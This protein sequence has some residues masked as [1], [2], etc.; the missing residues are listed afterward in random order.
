MS[1]KR[2]FLAGLAG[3]L[4]LAWL[5]YSPGL[6]GG[7]LFDDYVNLDALGFESPLSN[8]DAF[9]RYLSS[10]QADPTGR[11]VAM[12][13]FLLDAQTWPAAPAPFLRTNLIIH[14]GNGALLALLLRRLGREL[15]DDD[16]TCV[17]AALL[18][19]GLWLLHPL[20]VSTT[21][22]VVQRQAMLATSF[23]LLG[24]LAWTHGR[25]RLRANALRAG[26]AWM[27]AG[28]LAGGL[29]AG[30]SKANGF[31]L[32]LLALAIDWVLGARDFSATAERR[33]GQCRALLLVAP[34]AL[35][36]LALATQGLDARNYAGRDFTLGTRL[37]SEARVMVDYLRLLAVP[38][39]MSDGVFNDAF[40]ASTSW[41]SPATTLPAALLVASLLGA[42]FA[43]RRRA[44]AWSMGLLFFFAGHV[45][46]ST[47]LPLE[48]RYEHRNYLPA[49]LLFWP[50]A[51][52]LYRCRAAPALRHAAALALVLLV[53]FP[54]WQ[55]A[56]LW[57]DPQRLAATWLVAHPD[58]SRAIAA[59]AIALREAGRPQDA[60]RLLAGAWARAPNDAQIALNFV[61][62]RCAAGQLQA[63]DLRLLGRALAHA[64]AD[65]L[66]LRWLDN[67]IG[68]APGFA[69][70]LSPAQVEALADIVARNPAFAS[71]R[72]RQNLENL[73]GRIA[74]ARGEPAEAALH[75][76]QSL[77]AEVRP[78]VAAAQAA[79]LIDAGYHREAMQQLDYYESVSDRQARPPLGM[80]RVHDWLLRRQGY[81][82]DVFARLR[83]SAQAAPQ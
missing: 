48:L 36:L 40:R 2:W 53:A 62:S 46:E 21:L 18:G 61:E 5:V 22:Y 3:L 49:L 29:L 32:P 71:T 68:P 38:G 39:R 14:L 26:T 10:G 64:P 12:L 17:H 60:V 45:V 80:P 51:R 81:W 24:L 27:A 31:V 15:G 7:F 25:A 63:V 59:T 33:R 67:A 6:S 23:V 54:A 78:E 75:F 77:L 79:L 58:S 50:L 74:L 9:L 76:R 37:W 73:R 42:G 41:H 47:V 1:S 4:L 16:A 11:P 57:G 55:R 35:L 30:L 13:S 66:V 34:A 43:L 19:A 83:A 65:L 44:P 8:L 52:S 72:A 56:R 20:L 69:C 28:C 82:Q 70:R